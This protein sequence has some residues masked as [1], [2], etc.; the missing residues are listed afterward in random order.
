MLEPFDVAPRIQGLI[1]H[2]DDLS[3]AYAAVLKAKRQVAQLTP[4]VADCDRHAQLQASVEAA[5]ACRDALKSYVAQLKLGLID[6]RLRDLADAF[7]AERVKLDKLEHL[8]V[9]QKTQELALR[10][11][12]GQ[13]GGNRIAQIESDMARAQ[14]ELTQ[15]R[16]KAAR[17]DVW[18]KQLGLLQVASSEDLV[19]QQQTCLNLQEAERAHANA[20][21][22]TLMEQSTAFAMAR[23]ERDAVAAEVQSLKLRTSNID[24]QQI[25]VRAALCQALNLPETAMPFAGELIEVRDAERDWEGAIERVLHSFALSLL[26]PEAHYAR[27]AQ[28][29]DS[30]NMK[31]R[32]VYF[33][34]RTTKAL[35]AP[36]LHPDA[37]L[38]KINFKADSS[39]YNWL[40]QAVWARFNMV[41][42]ATTEQF[43]REPRALTR[44]GQTK[45][46]AGGER[47]EKDDRH[48][49]DDRSRY[50][51]GWRNAAK[52]RALE[53]QV[54]SLEAQVAHL[55]GRVAATQAARAASTERSSI[56]DKLAE[57]NDFRELD[58]ASVSLELA[59]WDD[60]LRQIK[61]SSDL[62]ETLTKQLD[63]LLTKRDATEQ[64]W[65]AQRD[66]HVRTQERTKAAQ[67][68]RES[69]EAGLGQSPADAGVAE[70]LDA[71]RQGRHAALASASATAPALTVEGCDALERELRESLQKA[72]DGDAQRASAVLEKII[73]AMRAYN[74]DYRQETLD[75]D[76]SMASAHEYRTRLQALQA[77][78]LPRFEDSFK[79]LLNENTINEVANFNSQLA[80]ERETIRE[81]ITR[82]NQSLVHIDYNPARFIVLEAQATA[83]A[84]VRDFQTELRLCL[85]GMLSGPT[86][87]PVSGTA[88]SAV[89]GSTA[90]VMA[91]T[92]QDT[93]Y[94]EAKFLQ[95]KAIIERL[96]GRE[97]QTDAD[98]RWTNKVTDVRNWFSFAASERWRED[99]REH[100]H[101]S[102]SGGKSGGQKEKLAY[103]ILAASLAY[104]FGLA[105]GETRSRSFRFVVIDEAFGRGS[106]E[107]AQY[108]LA[109]FERLNLQ[110]LIVTPLQKIHIIE[111][112]VSSVGFVHNEEGRESK[113]RN[114]S[115][116][117]YR[118]ERDRLATLVGQVQLKEP[119]PV[120]AQ[121]R[122]LDSASAPASGDLF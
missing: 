98:R 38:R 64:Q 30:T 101:Y 111:P 25:M 43:R 61:A 69:T 48:R 94:S 80:R 45:G 90:D 104:Q 47:H 10:A 23:Q 83:D 99:Q 53:D 31:A 9:E 50:V 59:R 34:V 62:L 70:R 65:T 26:V 37:L 60:E 114:L 55:G 3:R 58:W 57:V 51:L 79:R 33:S 122:V 4:L 54:R 78:D 42:C 18:R 115:I 39:L 8:R 93:Q 106:D 113:L 119:V 49:L 68:L 107:S 118:A 110:L 15:R 24:T 27:V 40:E 112:F 76:V 16:H 29:V 100:E 102:D 52:R 11:A 20:L 67:A 12:L 73:S 6:T 88:A 41:C 96:R 86:A 2:F 105:W 108:G 85:S 91:S 87:E 95:V 22:N 84:E 13:S 77:D 1:A 63:A 120:P 66:A 32:L 36:D 81:R 19:T 17:Y 71:L 7:A 74:T 82:I 103:T 14:I 89:A 117:D 75:F 92:G 28:W 56:L 21:Q 5:R 121:A 109:L 97:G 46:G 116:Q 44:A 72:I 35:G